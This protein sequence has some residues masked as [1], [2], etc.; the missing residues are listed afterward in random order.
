MRATYVLRG[1]RALA[2]A[3][4]VLRRAALG[5]LL[6]VPAAAL[7]LVIHGTSVGKIY[8]AGAASKNFL[9]REGGPLSSSVI[10]DVRR[11]V[12][13]LIDDERL[14]VR[15]NFPPGKAGSAISYAALQQHSSAICSF[16]ESLAPRVSELLGLRVAPTPRDDKSSLSVLVYSAE[17]DHIDWHHDLNFYRGRH[18]TVL[19]PLIVSAGV[20]SQLQV[21][22]PHGHGS[23]RAC[24]GEAPVVHA[25]AS[26]ETVEA[27]LGS[28]FATASGNS[29]KD[30]SVQVV[31]TVE[32]NL[33]CFEGAKV[34]HRVTPL[35]ASTRAW[36]SSWTPPPAEASGTVETLA[37]RIRAG[38]PVRVVLSMTFCTDSS[39]AGM[40]ATAQRRLKDM[41]Y[42]GLSALLN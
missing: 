17:G 29:F 7:G 15:F 6:A 28:R 27:V 18:F 31:P 20:D 35:G 12:L 5:A 8:D 33:I 25:S 13:R 38:A 9:L 34:F 23:A 14:C 36:E 1:A 4:P 3:L 42:F 26:Q 32:G 39:P 16:Y 24:G 37:E 19:V 21:C 22:V 40:F 10:D 30:A 2:P 11:E 41:T